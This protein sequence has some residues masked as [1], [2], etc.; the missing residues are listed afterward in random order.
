MTLNAAFKTKD[1]LYSN[2][3]KLHEMYCVIKLNVK[4]KKKYG[5]SSNKNVNLTTKS[6]L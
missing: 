3:I 6:K 1:I 2:L 4:I 5:R